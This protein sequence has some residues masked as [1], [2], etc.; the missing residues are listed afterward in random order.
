MGRP[1]VGKSALFNRF[2]RR[3]LAL[4]RACSTARHGIHCWGCLLISADT[5][6][7]HNTPDGHVTRDYRE[8][9]GSLADLQ[10]TAIDTSGGHQRCCVIHFREAPFCSANLAV[11]PLSPHCCRA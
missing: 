6:Q 4:V 10:F 11:K 5:A 8:G 3:G 2:L 7:V 9:L 1:N